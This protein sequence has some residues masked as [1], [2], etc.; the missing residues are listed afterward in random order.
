LYAPTLSIAA[1]DPATGEFGVAVQS[2]FLG[3]GAIVPHARSGAGAVATQAWFDPTSGDRAL[4]LL[5]REVA[6]EV[7]LH[8]LIA[9]DLSASRS[10]IGVIDASGGV[11]AWTGKDCPPWAGH[12][13]GDGFC[14]LGSFVVGPQAVVAMAETFAAA[15]GPFPERLV[16]ALRAG[17]RI[18]GMRSAALFVARERSGFA[19]KDDRYIDIR[20]DEHGQAAL[21]LDR[22]LR[23]YRA[24][25]WARLKEPIVVMDC[26]L[27]QL[28]QRLL[29]ELD[30]LEGERPGEWDEPTQEALRRLCGECG[31][32]KHLLMDGVT[33]PQWLLQRLLA[34][35]PRRY[36]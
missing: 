28:V 34:M 7:V 3:V 31:L 1:G 14:C 25:V 16:E 22:L 33:L 18:T 23:L 35:A 9:A 2:R 8:Q 12:L 15:S 19:W 26:E 21:E 30:W 4:R 29:H 6:A 10:Q 5:N 17:G 13:V 20:V 11:A 24:D 32:G 36:R 27:I